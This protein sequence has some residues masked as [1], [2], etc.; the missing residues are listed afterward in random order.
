MG[1]G[2]IWE[3]MEYAKIGKLTED[4]LDEIIAK[5]GGHRF[6]PDHSREKDPN[7]DYVLG[8]AVIELKLINEEGLEKEERRRKD[9]GHLSCKTI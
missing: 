6:S 4:D 9:C 8:N 2:A 3:T 1:C 7:T 5:L